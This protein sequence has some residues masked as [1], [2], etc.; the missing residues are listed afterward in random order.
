MALTKTQKNATIIFS[1][2]LL[3]S[4][5]FFFIK[6]I[7]FSSILQRSNESIWVDKSGRYSTSV[8]TIRS[9]DSCNTLSLITRSQDFKRLNCVSKIGDD[10]HFIIAETINTDGALAYWILK[11]DKDKVELSANQAVD[12]P[13]TFTEFSNQKKELQIDSLNFQKSFR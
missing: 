1:I 5:I 12:G 3:L 2:L 4:V 9:L 7:S 6:S 13:F 10:D 8:S 11:K